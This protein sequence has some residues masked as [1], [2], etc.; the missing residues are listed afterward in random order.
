VEVCNERGE[1]RYL[2]ER[3]D[4]SGGQRETANGFEASTGMYD[5]RETTAAKAGA[6]N[7]P[8]RAIAAAGERSQLCGA[9]LAYGTTGG[10]EGRLGRSRRWEMCM[11]GSRVY[12]LGRGGY[13][14]VTA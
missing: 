11:D 3:A 9:T 12:V 2:F 5:E 10:R 13:S 4:G 1:D 8:S 6:G 7:E 14:N